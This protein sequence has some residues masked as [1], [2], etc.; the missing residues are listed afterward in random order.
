MKQNKSYGSCE[1]T[2]VQSFDRERPKMEDVNLL[3]DAES[4]T[5]IFYSPLP[6]LYLDS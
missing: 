4:G 3:A 2:G 6:Q 1:I 5:P